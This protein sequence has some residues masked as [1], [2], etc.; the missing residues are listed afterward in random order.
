[1][2]EDIGMSKFLQNPTFIQSENIESPDSP[3][4][5]IPLVPGAVVRPVGQAR[6]PISTAGDRGIHVDVDAP[7]SR[8]VL[9]SPSSP[10]AHVHEGPPG[11]KKKLVHFV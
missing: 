11:K 5:D 7:K 2:E 6:V 8:L 4:L 1:M 3:G 10:H 9:I